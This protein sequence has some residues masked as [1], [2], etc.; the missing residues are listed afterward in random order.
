VFVCV[1]NLLQT[2]IRKGLIRGMFSVWDTQADVALDKAHVSLESLGVLSFRTHTLLSIDSALNDME[3]SIQ[4]SV[5]VIMHRLS[6]TKSHLSRM[7][8]YRTGQRV[9]IILSRP[10]L[11]HLVA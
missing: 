5:C 7:E 10:L 4:V 9:C 8:I 11:A 6:N 1:Q 2:E 3:I